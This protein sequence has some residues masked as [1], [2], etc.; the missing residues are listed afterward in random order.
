MVCVRVCPWAPVQDGNFSGFCEA[1]A[2]G[3]CQDAAISVTLA[4]PQDCTERRDEKD[5]R[6]QIN[7]PFCSRIV[8]VV[9]VFK[10]F[11]LFAFA[12]FVGFCFSG[13][14]TSWLLL[15]FA[16]RILSIT[17]RTVSLRCHTC[18][19]IRRGCSDCSAPPSFVRLCRDLTRQNQ[20]QTLNEP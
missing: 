15:A 12:F 4:Q 18:V 20:I 11:F 13:Y 16:F 19:L 2:V 6:K 3:G 17:G 9:F 5:V 14:P 7:G 8:L 1:L 10:C